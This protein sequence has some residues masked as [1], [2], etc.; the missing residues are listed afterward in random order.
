MYEEMKRP[1]AVR[2]PALTQKQ[3][4]ELL[5]QAGVLCGLTYCVDRRT[6]DGIEGVVKSLIKLVEE[7][8]DGRSGPAEY[9]MEGT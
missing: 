7:D 5:M 1:E 4:E 9:N 8:T 2:K 3:R 6:M